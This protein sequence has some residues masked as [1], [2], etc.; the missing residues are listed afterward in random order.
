MEISNKKA[1]VL[2][3]ENK[4]FEIAKTLGEKLTKD[5][6]GKNLL[7]V[8]ILKGALYFTSDLTKKIDLPLKLDVV[9]TSSYGNETVSSGN[10]KIV[11]DIDYDISDYDVLLVDDVLDTG[12][13]MKVLI[14][15]FKEKHP[16][17]I[18]S[19]VLF[20]KQDRRKVDL[21]ADYVG[22]EVP[23]YFLVGYGLDYAETYRNL[24]YVTIL[25]G[26]E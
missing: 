23:D 4:L 26:E 7:V 1:Q 22:M 20:N 11:K 18:K 17:S 3:D 24:P 8:S 15:H 10:V 9:I 12:N 14:E 19:C 6:E 13:T 16:K 25:T 21:K 2:C 5:Y